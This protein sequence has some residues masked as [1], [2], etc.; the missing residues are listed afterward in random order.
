MAPYSTGFTG[1]VGGFMLPQNFG[2]STFSLV[3]AA[4]GIL[5]FGPQASIVSVDGRPV[6]APEKARLFRFYKPPAT[7][8]AANGLM[9]A[10]HVP[11]RVRPR[12]W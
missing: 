10:I 11:N 9:D 6:K 7:L 4:P 2:S 12:R 3:I 5:M 1:S 8:T